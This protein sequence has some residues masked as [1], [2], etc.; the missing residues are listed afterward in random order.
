MVGGSI[1]R[2]NSDRSLCYPFLRI[3]ASPCNRLDSLVEPRYEMNPSG[4]FSR[5]LTMQW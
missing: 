2:C 3:T 1:Q 5:T 4:V